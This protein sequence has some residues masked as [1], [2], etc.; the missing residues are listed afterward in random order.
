MKT[1]RLSFLENVQQI[2]DVYDHGSGFYYIADFI[3]MNKNNKSIWNKK[4]SI[5]GL[6]ELTHTSSATITRFSQKLGLSGF[7]ELLMIMKI[8]DNQQVIKK[9]DYQKYYFNI[10]NYAW[11][12]KTIKHDNKENIFVL[13]K[14]YDYSIK[15]KRIFFFAYEKNIFLI[16]ALISLIEKEKVEVILVPINQ[17][18]IYKKNLLNLTNNDLVVIASLTLEEL[19]KELFQKINDLDLMTVIISKKWKS[20]Q[21]QKTKNKYFIKLASYEDQTFELN[22]SEISFVLYLKLILITLIKPKRGGE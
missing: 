21:L 19:F 10:T 16:K 5:F 17:E 20:S 15:K 1:L 9:D 11:L 4:L 3:V 18:K 14:L 2:L 8:D 22:G 7:K 13:N 12:C 6:A